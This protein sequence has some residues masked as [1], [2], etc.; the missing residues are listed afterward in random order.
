[1]SRSNR[2]N[3]R[4]R[5]FSN[6]KPPAAYVFKAHYSYADGSGGLALV[7][8]DSAAAALEAQGVWT[9]FFEFKMVPIVEVAQGLQIGFGNVRW[10]E[11]IS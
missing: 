7:E 2:R 1:M 6:W 10:R 3:V 4:S 8:I 9:P 11:S 5:D